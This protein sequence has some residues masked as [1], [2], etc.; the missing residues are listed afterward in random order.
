MKRGAET[1]GLPAAAGGARHDGAALAPER[2]LA[3]Q[4]LRAVGDPPVTLVLWDGSEVRVSADAGSRLVFR[5]RSALHRLL[6]FP[7][8]EFGE[9]YSAGR[10]E[11]EGDLV[12]FLET[13]Y[14]ALSSQ[15]RRNVVRSV[16]G[17]RYRAR[18]NTFEGS[19]DHIHHHYDIGNDF[20][21][22]WLDERMVYTCAYF[23]TPE[24]G[25]A[26]AQVAKLDHVC[27]KLRLQPGEQVVEAGCG[28]GALA[29]HM[30]RAYGARVRAYNISREQ[31]QYARERA[32]REG[33]EGRVEF[34]E[35]D[36]RTI[37]GQFDA[38]VSVG[39]L[40]HVGVENYATLGRVIDRCLKPHGRGLI[41][42]IGRNHPAPMNAWIEKRIFP[43]GNPPSLGE[44]ADVFEPHGFSVLDVENLRLHYART[45]EQW[46]ARF[47]AVAGR[48]AQMFDETFV[49]A[50]RLY[51]AGSVAAFRSGD[52]QLFQVLFARAGSNHVPWTRAHLYVTERSG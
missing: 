9:L 27:R 48:V 31:I 51:L 1:L 24:T 49:R 50:W 46:L 6:R 36:Y 37:A 2:W 18:R 25:L 4:L 35:G 10:L 16:F 3:R 47:E 21:Q 28:W 14:R 20:Y 33:L 30:A 42:S 32:R 22:L 12:G 38:F 19:R 45:T 17:W 26:E 41:H 34:I 52:L 15:R 7:D 43:G 44:M 39:M 11:V 13:V 5:D 40:E 23:P 8:L 29:L